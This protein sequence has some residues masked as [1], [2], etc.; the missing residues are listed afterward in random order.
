MVFGNNGSA[1]S[2]SNTNPSFKPI[3]NWT[4]SNIDPDSLARHNA[5]LKRMGFRDNAHAKGIF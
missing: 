4:G 3:T 5:S 1:P 2:G